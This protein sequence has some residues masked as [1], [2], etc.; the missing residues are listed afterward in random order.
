MECGWV[1]SGSPTG[2]LRVI[3]DGCVDL[4]VSSAGEV[5]IAGPATT[6]YDLHADRGCGYVGLRLR[7]GAAAAVVGRPVDE[8]CDHHVPVDSVFGVDPHRLAETVL[9]ATTPARRV[10]ALQRL[11]TDHWHRAEPALDTAVT[12]AVGMLRQRPDRPVSGLA[13]A[14]GLSERQLRRRFEAAVGFGP[15]RLSRILRFQRLLLLIRSHG[16]GRR[17][18]ELAVEANYADQPHMINECRALAGMSPAA[19]C[20]GMSVSSN[21]T[22]RQRP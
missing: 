22:P 15:K 8:L 14:V 12:G 1:R 10:A 9:T 19:L 2:A 6:F 3:P 7:T 5:V 11:L 21:T 13:D 16:A 17:W 18:A 20:G 4:F